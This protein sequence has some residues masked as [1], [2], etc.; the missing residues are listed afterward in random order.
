MESYSYYTVQDGSADPFLP[1][2][3]PRMNRSG[4]RDYVLF[5]TLQ[6]QGGK[7]KSCEIPAR[8]LFAMP[9]RWAGLLRQ[10]RRGGIAGRWRASTG[11][12]ALHQSIFFLI[13]SLKKTSLNRISLPSTS[14]IFFFL[15]KVMDFCIEP[16]VPRLF[17]RMKSF[18]NIALF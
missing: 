5:L 1:Q 8:H 18:E 16:G 7:T 2:I 6:E 14:M 17:S 13:H 11:C 15:S 9:S 4:F 10:G 12:F 3:F